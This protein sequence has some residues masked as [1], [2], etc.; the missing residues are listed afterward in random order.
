MRRLPGVEASTGSLGQGLS[1]GVG[2]ALAARLDGYDSRVYV[3]IGDGELDEGQVWEAAMA[4]HKFKLDNLVAIVD[5][6]GY[7]QTGPTAEVLDLQPLAPQVGGVRLVR[8]GD[9][10]PRHEARCS[11]PCRRPAQTKGRPS[12]IV[13]QHRQ[14]L[15]DPGPADQ[16]PEPPRQAADAEEAKAS[17]SRRSEQIGS[18]T[19]R[20]T[21][22]R[23]Q[24]SS[25]DHEEL[26]QIDPRSVRPGAGQARRGVSRHRRRRRRRAQ[27][28]AHRASSPRSSPSASSTSASPSRTWSASPAAWRRPA[29]GPGWPASPPSSCATPTTSCACRWPSRAWT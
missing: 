17:A 23:G 3:M 4:A 5:Q 26:G 22:P 28:D 2:H 25:I 8:P 12:V 20:S 19:C 13:A 6:N 15:P 29:S 14:G 27:L 10:R 24:R 7:Q 21:E 11:A 1:I 9:Q 18:R 16:R